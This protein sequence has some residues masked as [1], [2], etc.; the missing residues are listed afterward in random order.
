MTIDMKKMRE[1]LGTLKNKGGA[2]GFWRPQDGE[3]T[4][5]IVPT[6]D[7]DP[8]KDY[9]FHYNVGKNAGFSCPKKNY[10]D[11][12]PV[13]SFATKLYNEGT[14]DR[15]Q[16]IVDEVSDVWI[17]TD[18]DDLF[19]DCI[20]YVEDNYAY[21]YEIKDLVIEYLSLKCADVMSMADLE[22]MAIAEE[23]SKVIST[24]EQV[25]QGE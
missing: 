17:L 23:E 7:G 18:R 20:S 14:E 1:R 11:D 15:T 6:A 13:C 19:D 10:G 8:F 25:T 2:S 12:C 4:I 21:S 22:S 9:Y 5:R 24:Y 3:Q 16:R